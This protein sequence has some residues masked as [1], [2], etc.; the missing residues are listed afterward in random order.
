[1]S[2]SY[3]VKQTKD[4]KLPEVKA[5]LA[6][7]YWANTRTDETIQKSMDN[8]L[9]YGAFLQDSN[10]LIGFARIITD[11]ATTYYLC[12]VIVDEAYRGIGAGRALM[13]LISSDESFHGMRGM[14]LTETAASLYEKFGF[15][16]IDGLYMGKKS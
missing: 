3:Y 2:N 13:E 11:F 4:F 10:K 12:D 1:M 15:Q 6:Q 14:L 8:S 16:R 9:C 7:A 5:L